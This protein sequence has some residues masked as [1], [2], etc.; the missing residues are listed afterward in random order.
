MTIIDD[1]IDRSRAEQARDDNFDLNID[2]LRKKLEAKST[3]LRWLLIFRH[4]DRSY[5]KTGWALLSVIYADKH[6]GKVW[7]NYK[8]N[9][10]E[11][12]SFIKDLI[13]KYRNKRH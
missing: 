7:V 4:S 10:I 11:D 5:V 9:R 2:F 1:F 13:G 3:D 12:F 6:L 8:T